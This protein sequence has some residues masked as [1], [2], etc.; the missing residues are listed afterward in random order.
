MLSRQRSLSVALSF[1]LILA[2]SGCSVAFKDKPDSTGTL[3]LSSAAR[4]C[5]PCDSTNAA[6]G[7]GSGTSDDPFLVC[8]LA[9]LTHIDTQCATESNW[10]S[11]SF[12]QCADLDL[13][14][15]SGTPS[16][17]ICHATSFQGSYDGGGKKITAFYYS[18]PSQSGV[19][20]I[21]HLSGGTVSNL[22]LVNPTVSG[23]SQVGS[24]IGW[25]D[26]AAQV[27]S[28]SATGVSVTLS[29]GNGGGLVGKV[30]GAS[31]KI[32]GAT[33]SGAVTN[34][35]GGFTG[36]L[37]GT[38]V[39]S[40]NTS[41]NYLWNSSSSVTVTANA[42]G[43]NSVGGL[44]GYADSGSRVDHSFATGAVV[45]YGYVGGLAGFMDSGPGISKVEHSYATGHVT[46]T[47]IG[48]GGLI[49]DMN[50]CYVRNSHAT[51]DV[52]GADATG[53]L[54]GY[55]S[56]RWS[57]GL[58]S[59]SYAA[60][61]VTGH[62]G[63]G[64]LIGDG[65]IGIDNVYAV[66]NVSGHDRVG[67]LIG[68]TGD[69]QYWSGAVIPAV[70]N[71][72]S[73]GSVTGNSSVGGLIGSL[74]LVVTV[75]SPTLGNIT[76]TPGVDPLIVVTDSY[77]D[78]TTSGQATSDGGTAKTTALMQTASTYSTWPIAVWLISGGSYPTLK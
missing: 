62:D 18:N 4:L 65:G 78:T 48:S 27:V 45:G 28:C 21:E 8:S 25:M 71:A 19:G 52:S 31:A 30:Q 57:L 66:G 38:M 46:A 24:L 23:N 68:V 15:S 67:G 56:L 32:D 76:G 61:N 64:G 75:G 55:S 13:Q 20:F 63:V 34:T 39:P 40:P 7:G 6:T 41:L 5:A 11:K 29:G 73:K 33:V 36:G 9:Q 26:G 58:V 14:G 51:G 2:A 12:L 35:G 37:L 42:N 44:V 3:S 49:G 16:T 1:V 77:W 50:D 22:T 74:G 10:A 54:I 43:S 17:P 60:G 47:S 53:G 70:T 59:T 69:Q 72:Y